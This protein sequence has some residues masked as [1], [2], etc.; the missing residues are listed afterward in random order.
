MLNTHGNKKQLLGGFNLTLHSN[1]K[2]SSILQ[3]QINIIEF[4]L[5]IMGLMCRTVTQYNYFHLRDTFQ[6]TLVVNIR[7]TASTLNRQTQTD[8]HRQKFN[9]K[10]RLTSVVKLWSNSSYMVH[11]SANNNSKGDHG[12]Q[13]ARLALGLD[14]NGLKND[15]K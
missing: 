9:D 1:K 4:F 10:T 12:K 13:R 14:C 3:T 15:Y 5:Y 8:R 7:G 6:Q 11:F 2:L